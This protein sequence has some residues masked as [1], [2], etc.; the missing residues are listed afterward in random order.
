MSYTNFNYTWE[1]QPVVSKDSILF[2]VKINNTGKYDGDEVVQAYV[3]Y[4]GMAGMPV[5]ELKSFK[6]VHVKMNETGIA[7]FS[8]PLTELQKWD[9][10]KHQWKL[11]PGEY[12]LVLGGNSADEKLTAVLPIK[13]TK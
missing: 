8:I 1:K 3:Q 11:Y 4:P 6:R 13:K 2:S 12:K 9:M 7:G 10:E 5:K